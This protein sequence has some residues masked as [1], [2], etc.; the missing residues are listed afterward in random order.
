VARLSAAVSQEIGLSA[1]GAFDDAVAGMIGGFVVTDNRARVVLRNDPINP[2][3]ETV[4]L[5]PTRSHPPSVHLRR[6]FAAPGPEAQAAATAAVRGKYLE[7]MEYNTELVERVLSYPY[8]A[9]RETLRRDGA[10]AA[11]VSGMGPT[12]A[13]ITPKN[14]V[15]RVLS[16]LPGTRQE[17]LATSFAKRPTLE[18]VS[19]L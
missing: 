16:D 13:A 4:L 3:W 19:T 10:L 15:A 6:Q 17:H 12:L 9:L 18:S 5:I 11:G 2:D 1:T 14:C 7:A 8:R